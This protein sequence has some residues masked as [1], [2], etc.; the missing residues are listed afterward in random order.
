M[1]T[2]REMQDSFARL[3][4]KDKRLGFQK[5]YSFLEELADF[6]YYYAESQYLIA[7]SH[8]LEDR[9]FDYLRILELTLQASNVDLNTVDLLELNQIFQDLYFKYKR[10]LHIP[11]MHEDLIRRSLMRS[12]I[13]K[14]RDSEY[15]IQ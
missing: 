2:D 10:L 6:T 11:C 14:I 4:F 5:T 9:R 12:L 13:F 3:L 15:V 1:M 8:F 7:F